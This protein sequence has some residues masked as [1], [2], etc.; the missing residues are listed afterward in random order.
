[1]SALKKGFR[2]PKKN[3]RTNGK[4]SAVS[5]LPVQGMIHNKIKRFAADN[6]GIEEY[7]INSEEEAGELLVFM[8]AACSTL[9][10][11]HKG[12]SP[13]VKA[14]RHQCSVFKGHFKNRTALR[15][16]GSEDLE[17]HG[18]RLVVDG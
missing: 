9:A 3:E 16:I 5:K 4:T 10:A 15:Y 6:P 12:D 18:L 8:A 7:C 2:S 13:K 1:M 11:Q 17:I 14:Y